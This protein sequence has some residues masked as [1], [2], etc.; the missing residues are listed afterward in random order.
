M[1]TCT[2]R[3]LVHQERLAI[4]RLAP[5]APLPTWAQGAF[6]N[7]AR[8]SAELSIVCPQANVPPGVLAERD[9]IALGIEG[10]VPM[11]SIG[12]LAALCTIL[13]RVEVP[14][15]VLST[16]DTDWILVSAA[17]YPTARAALQAAGHEVLG[18]LPDA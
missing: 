10:T 12:I 14:V 18:E 3:F 2:F 1:P 15:F 7:L 4:A 13:A 5:M 16:Y 9:K 8:T 17:R 11:T 6:V